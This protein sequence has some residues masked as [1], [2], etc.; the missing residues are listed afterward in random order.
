M[1]SENINYLK[2][3]LEEGGISNAAKRLNISQPAL[4]SR[5]KKIE[6]DYGITV[7]DKKKK[8]GIL[9]EDGRK[10]LEFT[11]KKI[12]LEK[13]FKRYILDSKELK[14]GELKVGG[15]NLYT[16]CLLPKAVKELNTLYP[17][18]S[19]K[20]VNASVPVLTG[21]TAKGEL[22]LFISSSGK[23]S[24]GFIYENLMD[25]RLYIC[26][27]GEYEINRSLSEYAIAPEKFND[28]RKAVKSVPFEAFKDC[29][30]ILLDE[31]QLMGDVMRKLFR[32]YKI[33]P[34]NT[35]HTDQALTAYA[36]TKAGAGISLMFDK[37]I[38]RIHNGEDVRYYSVDDE[39]MKGNVRI[40]YAEQEYMPAVVKIFIEILKKI[41]DG[42]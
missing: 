18:I 24:R 7:L 21:M 41:N 14:T 15:T 2:I 1:D 34:G 25:T 35:H 32:K 37:I 29:P 12:Q 23:N 39:C 16:E 10:Y 6:E 5:I 33:S 30:F 19:V 4:S 27:P 26:V 17:G 28:K 31:S 11:E 40:V 36:L 3:I 8:P 22:D 13:S 38:S 20:I 42:R 9:T